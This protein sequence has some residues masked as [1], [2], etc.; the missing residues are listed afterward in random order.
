MTELVLTADQT[1]AKEAFVSFLLDPHEHVFVLKGYSG[2]GKSTLTGHLLESLSGIFKAARL[3]DPDFKE[4]EVQLT[5]TTNKAAENLAFLSG[6]S[7]PTVQSYLGLMVRKDYKT[8]ETYLAR[9]KNAPD[10]Y[11]KL[12]FVDEASYIDKELLKHIFQ[13]TKD[14]KIVFMG[15]PAQ[16]TP[17]KTHGTPVFDAKWPGAHLSQVVRQAEGHPIVDLSTKFRHTVNTGE[18]F[19]FKPDGVHVRHLSREEFNQEI[20]QEFSQPNW[21]F[22]DSKVLA[23]T[24]KCVIN[25]N[26]AIREHVGG[27]PDFEVGDYA[28]CNSFVGT[29]GKS[30]KT[31]QMVCITKISEPTVEEGVAGRYFTVDGSITLFMPNSLTERNAR[32][33]Q[34][35]A[36]DDYAVLSA[37]DT[38]WVDLRAAYAC[39]VNKAQGSTFDKVFIDLDDISR[40]NSGDQI[41]RMLYV[42]VSRAR[43]HVYLTGDFC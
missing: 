9:K 5:A 22:R 33:K 20:T 7:V 4:Y 41:A 34:A 13:I 40:C 35:K 29:Q 15:D 21:K 16:L 11:R 19:Q 2:T 17:V 39:T 3:I 28:I 38:S 36:E 30:L 1:A 23:W 12:L 6:Q 42:A 43:H 26:H 25:Y 18:F 8:D 27:S 32:I 14:S 37:I 10:L 24:N 31:D